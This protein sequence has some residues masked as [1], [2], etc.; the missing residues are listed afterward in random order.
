[1]P[2]EEDNIN[3]GRFYGEH[4]DVAA[5]YPLVADSPIRFGAKSQPR[6]CIFCGL[7]KPTQPYVTDLMRLQNLLGIEA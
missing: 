5:D 3:A 6:E 4:Y 2:T 1:M 7:G